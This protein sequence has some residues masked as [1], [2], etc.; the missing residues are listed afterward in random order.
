MNHRAEKLSY[1]PRGSTMKKTLILLSLPIASCVFSLVKETFTKSNI[2][3]RVRLMCM[4]Q[5][6]LT[7]I[8]LDSAIVRD[9]PSR[10]NNAACFLGYH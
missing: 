1:I 3:L 10:R 6:E 5:G 4:M 8:F 7:G 9:G 2:E